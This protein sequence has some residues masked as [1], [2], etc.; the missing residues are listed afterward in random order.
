MYFKKGLT[1]L[2]SGMLLMQCTHRQ[3]SFLHEGSV[4]VN[5]V[6]SVKYRSAL[7]RCH[8]TGGTRVVKI[9]GQLRC[10]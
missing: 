2:M 4:P 1:W 10:F 3:E 9:Q 5:H 8:R 6:E 7:I